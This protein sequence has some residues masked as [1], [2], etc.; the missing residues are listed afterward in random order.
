M[1]RTWCHLRAV[2][3]LPWTRRSDGWVEYLRLVQDKEKKITKKGGFKDFILSM[4]DWG[5]NLQAAATASTKEAVAQAS[6]SPDLKQ[7]AQ[8]FLCSLR[9]DSRLLL[10]DYFNLL[11][12]KKKK[13]KK[14]EKKK[15]SNAG[16]G[17]KKG[18]IH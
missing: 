2:W 9:S 5:P 14:K 1:G 11:K 16:K 13:S 15:K 3:L 10:C 7:L 12:K 18:L 6:Q 4:E 8:I 17:E